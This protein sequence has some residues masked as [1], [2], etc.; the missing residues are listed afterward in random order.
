MY[1]PHVYAHELLVLL[2]KQN[3]CFHINLKT[4]DTS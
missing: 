3:W 2:L 4:K 1:I